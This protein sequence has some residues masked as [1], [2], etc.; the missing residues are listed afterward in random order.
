MSQDLIYRAA[1]AEYRF[2]LSR[3]DWQL[4]QSLRQHL[5][6]DVDALFDVPELG[7]KIV[8]SVDQ[9]RKSATRLSEFI[10]QRNE[11][12]PYTYQFK[13]ERS[14]HPSVPAGGFSTGGMSGIRLPEDRFHVYSIRAGFDECYLRKM[15]IGTDGRGIEIEKLDLRGTTRLATETL[16]TIAIRR[17]R[18]RTDLNVAIT[19]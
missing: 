2:P 10:V 17:T 13:C 5:P 9:L 4:T 14:I 8:V 15:A 6:D 19:Y 18:K 1:C 3:S 12:L 16:G 11:L 7:T